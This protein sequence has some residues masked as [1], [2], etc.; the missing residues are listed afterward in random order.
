MDDFTQLGLLTLLVAGLTAI[1]MRLRQGWR[2]NAGGIAQHALMAGVGGAGLLGFAPGPCTWL[3]WG[4][5]VAFAL[6][7]FVLVRRLTA[8]LSL[9]DTAMARE[10]AG[11][12][13][14]L[15]WGAPGRFWTDCVQ[16]TVLAVEGELPAA[17]A[18]LVAYMVPG[19][20]TPYR[21]MALAR[22][23]A[24]RV[25]ARAW[26]VL[27]DEY[28]VRY[29]EGGQPLPPGVLDGAMRAYLELGE[30][31][32]ARAVFARGEEAA[33]RRSRHDVLL[34][35]TAFYAFA[36]DSGALEGVLAAVALP[37]YA[38][39]AWRGRCLAANGHPEAARATL[40]RA[41][42]TTPEEQRHFHARLAAGLVELGSWPHPGRDPATAAEVEAFRPLLELRLQQA[43]LQ[44]PA[45]RIRTTLALIALC[46]VAFIPAHLY[47]LFP[48]DARTLALADEALTRFGL[49]SVA[50]HGEPWRLGSYM[51]LH[52]SGL[53]LG[54]N[55]LLLWVCGIQVEGFF[56][57]WLL[58]L[59]FLLSGVAGGALQLVMQPTS[60]A[61]GASGAVLGLLGAVIAGYWRRREGV[62]PAVRRDRV[63]RLVLIA[64]FQI[65][66]DQVYAS[67]IAVWVHAGGLAT[68][69]LLGMLWPLR[70]AGI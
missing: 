66:L 25:V 69:V 22:L 14:L 38:A 54:T 44:A 7:P 63:A 40:E 32:K 46:V 39:D 53:H 19:V 9:L 64:A 60:Q 35:A 11:R 42:A 47:S 45:P 48:A 12:V 31:A 6:W 5:F 18:K 10:E 1:A 29:A 57:A 65:A 41:L 62:A 30:V 3:G 68:G 16:A 15:I 67:Q 23:H 20:P 17:E 50:W 70:R 33:S 37:A 28:E 24:V 49:T 43:D 2:W 59:T 34:Q 51:L 21:A 58:L 4:L 56:G 52:A 13:R 8:Q 26:P 36:G 61:I 55:M 27:I